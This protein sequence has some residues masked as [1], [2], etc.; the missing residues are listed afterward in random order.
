MTRFSY[1]SKGVIDILARVSVINRLVNFLNKRRKTISLGFLCKM[2]T[3]ILSILLASANAIELTQDTWDESTAGKA[4]FVKFFA[5]WCG[6]CK[7]MK[8]AWDNLMQDFEDSEEVLV[9]DV[10]CIEAG[11]SLCEK[12]GVKGFP[13]I[14]YGSPDDLQDY[15]GSREHPELVKFAETLK[16]GCIAETLENCS[17][18]EKETIEELKEKSVEDLRVLVLAEAKE[19]EQANTDFK[20]EVE[21]LQKKYE[22]LAKDKESTLEDIKGRYNV[23][24]VKQLIKLGESKTDL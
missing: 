10:D 20:E 8:P 4:V 2:K 21:K 15:K 12:V 5:P 16:P 18:E 1:A 9:A 24:F 23:G 13:T 7:R 14:K 22:Q 17:E 6:H 19:R 11:K 3:I